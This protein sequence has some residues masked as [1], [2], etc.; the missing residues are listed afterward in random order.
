MWVKLQKTY[1][2][3]QFIGLL[4]CRTFGGQRWEWSWLDLESW[5]PERLRISCEVSRLKRGAKWTR[6]TELEVRC[7]GLNQ[8]ARGSVQV[9][10]WFRWESDGRDLPTWR[11]SLINLH[12]VKYAIASWR[13]DSVFGEGSRSGVLVT[14][15]KYC[16]GD[17]WLNRGARRC[18]DRR[19]RSSEDKDH[20]ETDSV[21]PVRHAL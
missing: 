19:F 12:V 18:K 15:K 1:A 10:W 3:N 13:L 20:E 17:L 14:S 11:E 5:D 16:L 9:P 7:D 4:L 6:M 2:Q 21:S 8:A